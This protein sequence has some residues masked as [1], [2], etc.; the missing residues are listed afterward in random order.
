MHINFISLA[1]SH[2]PLMLKWLETP[3]VKAWWNKE[4]KWTPALIEKKYTDYVKGYKLEK[5]VPKPIGAYIIY[6]ESTPIGYIQIY[7][8]YDFARSKLLTGL[9]ESLAAFDVFIG[10]PDYLKRGIGSRAIIQFLEKH[11]AAYTHIFVDPENANLAAI[12]AYEKA[13]FKKIN[14]T[15]NINETWMIRKQ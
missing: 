13:G 14:P 2:F 4:I 8:A 12:R 7:N 6:A 15:Q 1:E 5:N 11:G 10:E 3:H 9:P